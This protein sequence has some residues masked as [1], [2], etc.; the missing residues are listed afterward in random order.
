MAAHAPIKAGVR[1][2]TA[3]R[4]KIFDVDSGVIEKLFTNL[5]EDQLASLS[6]YIATLLK[7]VECQYAELAGEMV[8]THTRFPQRRLAW[9][10][11]DAQCAGPVRDTY[12][13]FEQLRHVAVRQSKVAVAT[14]AFH[15]DQPRIE[16]LGKMR[17]GC[18]LGQIGHI[19][20]L[21]RSQRFPCH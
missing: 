10:R 6:A 12:Q 1:Q 11:A 18:L 3:L 15:S 14:L 16:H 19:G 21:G 7:T 8:V 2:A 17:T 4:G 9:A 20:E 5:G 13:A